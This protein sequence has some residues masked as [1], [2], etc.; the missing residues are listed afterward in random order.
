[1]SEGQNQLDTRALELAK[2]ASARAERAQ[3]SLE[4]HEKDCERRYMEISGKYD[5]LTEKMDITNIRRSEQFASLH[6]KL[7]KVKDRSTDWWRGFA[8]ALISLLIIVV[9][10]LL[11]NGSPFLRTP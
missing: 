2:D 8:V 4:K 9:G 6:E 10:Y 11:A 1:L 3:Q 5:G 7:D